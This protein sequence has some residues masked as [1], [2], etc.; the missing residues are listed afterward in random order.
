MKSMA[1][2][3]ENTKTG[4]KSIDDLIE[5]TQQAMHEFESVKQR[6][7]QTHSSFKPKRPSLLNFKGPKLYLKKSN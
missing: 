1:I 7:D 6:I 4:W 3:L 2:K 5:D